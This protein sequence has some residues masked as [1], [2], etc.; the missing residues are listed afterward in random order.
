V[1]S[2][3]KKGGGKNFGVTARIEGILV[4]EGRTGG[5]MGLW[6]N[7]KDANAGK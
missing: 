5:Q 7:G 6:L 1:W 3:A 2:L 4:T